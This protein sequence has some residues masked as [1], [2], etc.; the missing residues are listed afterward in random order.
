[1]RVRFI[2]PGDM[3]QAIASHLPTIQP[4]ASEVIPALREA[5]AAERDRRRFGERS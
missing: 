3:A 4:F 5:A 2:G 1:M